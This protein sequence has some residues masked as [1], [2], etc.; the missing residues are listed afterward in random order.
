MGDEVVARETLSLLVVAA[1]IWLST[2]LQAGSVDAQQPA[3][4]HGPLVGAVTESSA[5]VW[6]RADSAAQVGIR[7]GTDPDLASYTET[8]QVAAEASTDYTAKISLS[9]L[10]PLTVYYIDVLVDDVSQLA[11]PYPRFET[12]APPGEE[13]AFKFVVFSDFRRVIDGGLPH[14]E[15]FASADAEEP[16]FVLIGGDFDHTNG[17][18]LEVKRQ[19]FKNLYSLG[20]D[21]DDFVNLIFRHYPV[22]HVWDDHDYGCDNGDKLYPIKDVSLAVL[23]EFFPVYPMSQYGCWQRFSYGNADFFLMDSRSQ[24]DPDTD[25]DG[26]DKSM[27]DG[28]NL[29]QSGQLHWLLR[30]LME[31]SARWKFVKTPS[32]FNGTTSKPDSWSQFQYE[33]ELILG[34]IEANGIQGVVMISGDFHFGAIDDGTNSGVPEIM[35]PPANHQWCRHALSEYYGHWSE[36]VYSIEEIGDTC[37]GYG[38][39]TVLTNPDCVILEIKDAEGDTRVRYPICPYVSHLPLVAGASSGEDLSL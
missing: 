24:R 26:S 7:Y 5:V 25:P 36:G 19:I 10:I 13:V 34:F 29:G 6:V 8:P 23:G 2:M 17:N 18:N 28:D 33:R 14:A 20:N 35:V 11:A 30:G 1:C 27:L 9:G 12:F 4:T 3:L 21:M 39:V 37:W 15:T 16:A 38:L 31:S 32:V 22:A